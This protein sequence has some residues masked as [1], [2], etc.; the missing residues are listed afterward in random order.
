[1]DTI[2]SE[3][4]NDAS[5]APTGYS[6]IGRPRNGRMFLRGIRLLPPRA[7]IIANAFSFV[8]RSPLLSLCPFGQD[9]MFNIKHAKAVNS[10]GEKLTVNVLSLKFSFP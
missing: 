5:A 1:V 4:A 9:Y 2:T 3:N 7:G 8:F 10:N 6:I